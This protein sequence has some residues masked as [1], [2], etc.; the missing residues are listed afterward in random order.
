M[1]RDNKYQRVD[2]VRLHENKRNRSSGALQLRER[3]CAT[4]IRGCS[5]VKD[6]NGTAALF[7]LAIPEL[8]PS[9]TNPTSSFLVLYRIPLISGQSAIDTFNW[10]QYD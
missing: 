8:Q 2:F 10:K 3:N 4:Y 7:L 5:H 6:E 1:F 9:T